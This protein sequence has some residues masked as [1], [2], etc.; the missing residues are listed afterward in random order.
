MIGIKIII[1]KLIKRNDQMH[2]ILDPNYDIPIR[3]LFFIYLFM[4]TNFFNFDY[5][6]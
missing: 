2:N 3:V 5:T 6:Y 4:F 1:E